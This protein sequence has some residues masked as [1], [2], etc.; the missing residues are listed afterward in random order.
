MSTTGKS[1]ADTERELRQQIES[2]RA[3]LVESLATLT[4][5]VQPRVQVGYV[6]EDLKYRAEEAKYD[7]L[8]TVDEARDGNREAIKKLAVAAGVFAASIG[9]MMLRKAVKKRHR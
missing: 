9:V 1:L 8:T 2:S 4:H 5:V 7:V 6:A 3:N